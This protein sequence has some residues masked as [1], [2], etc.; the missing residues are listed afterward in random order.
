MKIYIR[1]FFRWDDKKID[2]LPDYMQTFYVA[3][4]NFRKSLGEEFAKK[5]DV[6]HSP[7]PKNK[8]ETIMLASFLLE[9][10]FYVLIMYICIYHYYMMYDNSFEFK[11]EIQILLSYHTFNCN[12]I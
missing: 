7:H 3:P 8:Y 11:F 1:L 5:G 4:I 9:L 12:C 6:M 10:T 2:D